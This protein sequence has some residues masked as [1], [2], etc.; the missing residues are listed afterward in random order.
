MFN[1]TFH[2]NQALRAL[3]QMLD[4]AVVTLQVAVLSM[5]IGV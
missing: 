5:V 2:W 3:P 1:Y 4:G